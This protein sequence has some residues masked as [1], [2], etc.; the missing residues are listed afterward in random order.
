MGIADVNAL[1]HAEIHR[2]VE[3]FVQALHQRLS[4]GPQRFVPAIFAQRT[5]SF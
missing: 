4:L 2:F 3:L 5:Q 1:E